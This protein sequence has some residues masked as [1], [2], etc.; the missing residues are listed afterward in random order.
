MLEF[1]SRQRLTAVLRAT[2]ATEADLIFKKIN[3]ITAPKSKQGLEM[4]LGG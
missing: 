2:W 4:W 1:R 3:K